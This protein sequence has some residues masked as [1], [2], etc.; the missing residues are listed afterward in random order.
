MRA[1]K[2]LP[3]EASAKAGQI[4]IQIIIA[5][6]VFAILS[7]ALITLLLTTYELT[8][9][10]RA[11]TTAKALAQERI[12]L[13]RNLPFDNVGTQGGIPAGDLPQTEQRLVNGLPYTI[14]TSVVYVD[15]PFDDVAPA[16][17]LPN[18]YK[19]ARVEISWPGIARS[20]NNPV[21][22]VTDISPR[23]VETTTG[24][25]TLSI[26]VFNAQG[27][28]VSQAQALIQAP[29]ASP[30]IDLNLQTGDNGLIILPGAPAC[31]SCYQIT[32]TKNGFSTDKTYSTSE[33][34]NPAKPHQTI[35]ESELTEVS[36]AIDQTAT[37]EINSTSSRASSFAPEPNV[38]FILQGQKTIG[39]NELGEPVYKYNETLI[40]GS[41]GSLSVENLEWDSYKILLP[42]TSVYSLSGIN[43]LLPLALEPN[44]TQS[45]SF[46]LNPFSDNNLR[47]VFLDQSNSPIS[48]ISATLTYLPQYEETTI[49][50]DPQNPDFGQSFFE[51]P[52]PQHYQLTATASGYID[53]AS[54]VTITGQSEVTVIMTEQ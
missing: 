35:I 9:F 7:H 21:T 15:D 24:G 18:D 43:P 11:R 1:Q 6:G 48:S 40:T 54:Q 22:F 17:L 30:P 19:R 49:S 27:E 31:I 33:V 2:G 52:F 53:S 51:V 5:V 10:T 20:A 28:P 29:T 34:A 47:A 25:G 3:A 26:L 44:S 45:V 38:P 4:Y 32:V 36:F 41:S 46:S 37:M 42:D 8:S 39:A 16:D 23:S 14:K 50:G 13:I 12:E